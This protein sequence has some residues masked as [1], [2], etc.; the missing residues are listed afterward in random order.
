MAYFSIH[1]Y[2]RGLGLNEALIEI[3]EEAPKPPTF[4]EQIYEAVSELH[5]EMGSDNQKIRVSLNMV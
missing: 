4:K 3:R 2:L 5:K 1:N